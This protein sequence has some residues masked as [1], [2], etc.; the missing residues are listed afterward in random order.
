MLLPVAPGTVIELPHWA[1]PVLARNDHRVI[2][3]PPFELTE[4]CMVA[5]SEPAVNDTVGIGGAPRSTV[6]LKLKV[7][8]SPSPSVTV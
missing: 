7:A 2:A 3:L 4:A 1:P 8:E 5:L 6:M